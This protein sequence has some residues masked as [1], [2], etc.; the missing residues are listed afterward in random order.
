MAERD[1]RQ[2]L[3]LKIRS[4]GR[5]FRT[6][7]RASGARRESSRAPDRAE[8]VNPPTLPPRTERLNG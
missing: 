6:P 2:K 5:K 4:A 8:V 1:A 3:R 7:I